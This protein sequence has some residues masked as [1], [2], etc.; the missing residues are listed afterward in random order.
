MM[1]VRN[2]RTGFEQQN[3]I[4]VA[5]DDISLTLHRGEILG[6]VGESGS[7]KTQVALAIMRLLNKPAVTLG[8]EVLLD[9]DDL[10]K[11][12]DREIRRI[13]GNRMAMIFQDSL[14]ALDPVHT[15]GA[16]MLEM[17]MQHQRIDKRKAKQKCLAL[18]SDVGMHNPE[19]VMRSYPFEL[20]GG[21]CQRV[22]IAMALLNDPELLIADEPTTAL[23]V[24]V[25]AQILEL[26]MELRDKR[27][28]SIIIITHDLGVVAEVTDRT[29]VLYLGKIMEI[30]DTKEF[31]R[32]PRHPYTQGLLRSM[33]D[34]ANAERA[35]PMIPGMVP[36]LT[37]IPSGCRFSTRCSM[38]ASECQSADFPDHM[39]GVGHLFRCPKVCIEEERQT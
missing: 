39:F 25:Q 9:G 16:Q 33:P 22:M 2:L 29:A 23:D 36:E 3:G 27:N 34:G 17:L 5:V 26:L 7:G 30:G 15:C 14:A 31:L 18:L 11:K 1:E 28:M 12:T 24:T 13:Q 19:Q 35:L 6:I 38:A 8:G 32:N 37:E 20:S 10:L 4:L 21:M